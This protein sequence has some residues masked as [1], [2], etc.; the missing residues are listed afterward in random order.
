VAAHGTGAIQVL[1]FRAALCH[2][3]CPHQSFLLNLKALLEPFG[4]TRDDTG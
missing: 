3:D 1:D 2:A 4:S